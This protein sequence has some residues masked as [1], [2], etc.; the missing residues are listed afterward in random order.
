M[1]RALHSEEGSA[2]A[3]FVMVSALL[4]VLTLTVIQL[5]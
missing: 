3:E 5:G 2:V 4:T 1:T